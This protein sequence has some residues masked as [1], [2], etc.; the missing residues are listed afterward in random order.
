VIPLRSVTVSLTCLCGPHVLLPGNKVVKMENVGVEYDGRQ[1]IKNF[2][3]NFI[4]GTYFVSH[5]YRVGQN[6]ISAPYMTNCTVICL[7]KILC[8]H[9][10]YQK[11]YGSDQ[12]YT[13]AVFFARY[14]SEF[15]KCL[16][17]EWLPLVLLACM[18]T[19]KAAPITWKAM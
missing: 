5:K 2:T 1:I 13:L 4:P 19:K 3:Y 9:R 6:C 8:V 10:V 15:V 12:P 11:M 16:S 17:F 7:L 14:E 18:F